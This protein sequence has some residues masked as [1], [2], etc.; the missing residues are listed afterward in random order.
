MGNQER[1]ARRRLVRKEATKKMRAGKLESKTS[2][3]QA[4][5]FECKRVYE[6]EKKEDCG[7]REGRKLESYEENNVLE[8]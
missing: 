2:G 5:R 6:E 8:E 3:I 7:S 4:E 1:F